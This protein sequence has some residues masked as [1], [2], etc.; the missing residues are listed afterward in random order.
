L[1]EAELF[2]AFPGRTF[3]PAGEECG[4]V[5]DD[6][7]GCPECGAGAPQ[8]G[9]LFLDG[10]HIPE[11]P[12]FARTIAGEIVVSAKAVEVFRK[13]GFTGAEFNAVALSDKGSS[14]SI[15]H[16]QLNVR[17]P[18]VQLDQRTRLG[19]GPFDESAVGHCPLGDL[20]GLNLVSE[21]SIKRGSWTSSD[22]SA[23]AQWV[24]VRRGLLRPHRLVLLSSHAR[25]A[26][27]EAGLT[28]LVVEVAQVVG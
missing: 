10:R 3:E 5:Y 26:I 24:G 12:D 9:P 14:E 25:R 1:A 16:Y 21:V 8:V 18:F 23:T 15:D 17:G 2:Y 19:E 7:R 27:Q 22:F 28:G 4:T 6:T 11:Q 20:A 13:N